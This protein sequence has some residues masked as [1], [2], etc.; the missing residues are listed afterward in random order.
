MTESAVITAQATVHVGVAQARR[1]FM[2]LE[3]HP[4]RYRFETHAGFT[5]DQGGERRFGQVGARFQTRERFYGLRLR[6]GFE[7]TEV[8]DDHFRFRLVRPAAPVW[9]AFVI[10]EAGAAATNLRL[11]IGGTNRLGAWLLRL[12]LVRGAV[13]R[14][15]HGEVQHVKASM[16]AVSAPCGSGIEPH[17]PTSH[18]ST[19]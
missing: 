5:F 6:L 11:A 10:E 15:I 19:A 8:G 14:Q 4:E 1:W 12:P 3:T 2:E 9:G 16:E 7:L 13:R 17:S 18:P